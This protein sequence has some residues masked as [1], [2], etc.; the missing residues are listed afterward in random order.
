MIRT[1]SATVLT[2]LVLTTAALAST[3]ATADGGGLKAL[4]RPN[5]EIFGG[6]PKVTDRATWR[7]R[8]K[9]H[10]R[11]GSTF[12][13]ALDGGR[14]RSCASPYQ[15]HVRPGTHTIEIRAK[16]DGVEEKTPARYTWTYAPAER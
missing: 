12:T 13:C 2:T 5:T 15:V 1:R 11:H 4:E 7:F 14:A 8:F 16:R 3:P 6:P 9:T 10:P